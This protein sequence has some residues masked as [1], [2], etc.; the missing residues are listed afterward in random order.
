MLW[1]K[2][3]NLNLESEK[4]LQL[5]NTTNITRP[6][7]CLS[8]SRQF[9]RRK[10]SDILP[11]DCLQVT[12]IVWNFIRKHQSF[13]QFVGSLPLWCLKIQIRSTVVS[14]PNIFNG[15]KFPCFTLQLAEFL[16]FIKTSLADIS[17]TRALTFVGELEF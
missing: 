4:Y 11:R 6:Q 1:G 3:R 16:N 17:S 10:Y 8:Y 12:L 14:S 13:A 2:F 5:S 7:Y 9:A 15:A